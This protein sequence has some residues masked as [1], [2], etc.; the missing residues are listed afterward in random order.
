MFSLRRSGAFSFA[1][2]GWAEGQA[3][4]LSHARA[5]ESDVMKNILGRVGYLSAA[6]REK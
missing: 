2:R 5:S 4:G 3:D 6:V 1:A